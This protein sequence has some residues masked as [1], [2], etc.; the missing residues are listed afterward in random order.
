MKRPFVNSEEPIERVVGRRTKTSDPLSVSSSR[1]ADAIAW[2][3]AFGGIR[4]RRGVYR[5]RTHE[6]ADEWLWKAIARPTT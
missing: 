2:R 1:R 5:F 4:I 6:D 3:E